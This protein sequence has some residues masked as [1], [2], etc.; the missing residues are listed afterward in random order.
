MLEQKIEQ[1]FIDSADIKY[2]GAQALAVPVAAAVQALL[3]SLTGGGKVLCAGT[4]LSAL[5]AQWFAHLCVTGFERQRPELAA[6]AL[7]WPLSLGA[8]DEAVNT[9]NAVAGEGA[10]ASAYRPQGLAQQ[11]RALGQAGD[12]LLLF[13]LKGQEPSLLAALAAAHERD[14]VAVVL[15][16]RDAG[17]L[18]QQLREMDV[19]IAV[20]H[21]RPA[22]VLELHNLI[23]HCLCDGIDAQL[24][25]E[26]EWL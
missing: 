13:S 21:E 20:A 9:L 19:L 16:G 2:Q 4:G 22:R 15:T 25:G 7:P 10:L 1:H 5:Q 12:V 23:V 17:S 18:G 11:V 24:L 14:M 26:Q 3:A 8:E 6:L